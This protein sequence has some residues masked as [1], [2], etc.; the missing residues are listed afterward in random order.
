MIRSYKTTTMSFHIIIGG[1]KTKKGDFI[2]YD[3]NHN[4]VFFS[5]KT[6]LCNNFDTIGKNIPFFCFANVKEIKSNNTKIKTLSAYKVTSVFLEAVKYVSDLVDIEQSNSIENFGYSILLKKLFSEYDLYNE[7]TNY[8]KNNKFGFNRDKGEENYNLPYL[9]LSINCFGLKQKLDKYNNFYG[10]DSWIVNN[11]DENCR[12]FDEYE[13]LWSIEK[14]NIKNAF[15]I[16]IIPLYKS[17]KTVYKEID[18]PSDKP[19][20]KIITKNILKSFDLNR[21]EYFDQFY[22]LRDA[23]FEVNADKLMYHLEHRFDY[24][25]RLKN[26]FDTMYVYGITPIINEIDYEKKKISIEKIQQNLVDIIEILE[27]EKIYNVV[28]LPPDFI[29]FGVLQEVDYHLYPPENDL[30]RSYDGWAELGE[31]EIKRMDEETDGFWRIENDF[32]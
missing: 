1:N 3:S 24:V 20:I 16:N 18:A 13:I 7:K 6:Y 17:L 12:E 14:R 30:H 8:L 10:Y 31:Q 25:E 11:E 32:E 22:Q 28:I 27:K 26:A 29:H 23:K 21:H 19:V 15:K 9:F 4:S 2:G 5:Q